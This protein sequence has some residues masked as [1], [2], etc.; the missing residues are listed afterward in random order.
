[1]ARQVFAGGFVSLVPAE[2]RRSRSAL[3]S[4]KA[5]FAFEPNERGLIRREARHINSNRT[6]VPYGD[7]AHLAH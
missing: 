1:M 4:G 7:T 5:L 3:G 6:A 2:Q